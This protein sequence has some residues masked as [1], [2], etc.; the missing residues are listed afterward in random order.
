MTFFEELNN[1]N[2]YG[3][4]LKNIQLKKNIISFLCRNGSYTIADV[5]K[6]VNLSV[7]KVTNLISE[8]IQDG[9][10][11]DL[12][13]VESTGGRKPNLYGMVGNSVFFLGVDIKQNHINIGLTDLQKNLIEIKENIPYK[14]TNSPESLIDLIDIIKNFIK[15]LSIKKEKILGLGVNLSGRINHDTGYSYSFFNF[16]EEPLSKSLEK[17]LSIKT[18]LENDSRA[19]AY[20]EFNSGLVKEEKNVLFLNLDHGIG[21]GVMINSQ[22]YYGKSGFAGEF[23]HIPLF[24]NNIICQCGK[25]G[26]LETEG[27]GWALTRNFKEKVEAGT[28]SILVKK[29]D[30]SF[31]LNQIDMDSIIEAANKDDVLAIDLI[32]DLGDKLGRGIALLINIFNPELVIVGGSLAKTGE[33]LILPIKSAINKY[34]LSLVNSDTKIKISLLGEKSGVIGACLLARNRLLNLD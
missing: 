13:K 3:V 18:F 19:M 7:P 9:L 17:E 5:C 30:P 26:C 20:G 6:E 33:Y 22:L 32:A 1:E 12:G 10:V 34:S 4:A 23:G 14:L 31:S 11:E 2:T 27:S 24:N 16:N 15:N 29:N 21:M 28:S 8:L 25:K